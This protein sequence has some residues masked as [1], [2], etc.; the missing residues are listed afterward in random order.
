MAVRSTSNLGP[1]LIDLEGLSLTETESNWLL[2]PAVGGVIF[3]ARNY[4]S[5]S[6]LQSLVA[7]I[8]SLRPELLL[9]VD[10]EGG[11]VQ[12]FRS[13]FTRLPAS[14]RLSV[15]AQ[16]LGM[17][18]ELACEA[19][20]YLMASELVDQDIDFSFAPVL[21]VDYGHN[22]VVGDRAFGGSAGEVS[23]RAL[24]YARG[25]KALG[26]ARVGKH[27][28]GHGFVQVDTH[29][30]MASDPRSREALELA[31]LGVFRR[32][33]E[34]H[35]EGLMPAHV[36]FPEIDSEPASR[37]PVW[38]QQILRGEMAF[39]GTIISD[40]LGMAGASNAPGAARVEASLEAG[41]DLV[42]LCNSPDQQAQAIEVVEKRLERIPSTAE[43][44]KRRQGLRRQPRSDNA[45]LAQSAGRLRMALM[46]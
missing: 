34:A 25:M 11:R 9:T 4:E 10:Q 38:L 6:Q 22:A 29:V 12:R 18:D 41:C 21:D 33:V 19:A 44:Q 31:D 7:S 36:I 16:E 3:F 30:A 23:R 14:G 24:A 5:V 42:M 39:E 46:A 43:Q 35:F 8:R 1:L 13:G 17:S 37:S 45:T 27:Y 20:G 32:A 2:S 40:D 15:L 28:P 26:M